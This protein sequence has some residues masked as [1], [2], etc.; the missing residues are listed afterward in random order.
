MQEKNFT[1]SRTRNSA[2]A[3]TYLP[4]ASYPAETHDEE[5]EGFCESG[6]Q[7]AEQKIAEGKYAEAEAICREILTDQYNPNCHAAAELLAHLQQPGYFN[8]TMGPKFIAKVEDV[9]KLLADAEGYYQSGRYDLAFKK[10]EQV[11]GSIPTTSPPAAVKRRVDNMNIITAKKPITRR[12]RAALAGAEGLG[13]TGPPIRPGRWD[14]W[15]TL[16]KRT[17]VARRG[18]RPSSTPSSFRGLNSGMRAFA[19]RS[20]FFANRRPRTIPH[21]KA[22][23]ASILCSV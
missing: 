20:I 12:A 13:R 5:I 15:R 3:V 10:Y 1:R 8:K 2:I 21:R 19:K 14:R 7:L 22:A 16:F 23:K 17:P 4:D 9:K 18:S 11:L 6:V